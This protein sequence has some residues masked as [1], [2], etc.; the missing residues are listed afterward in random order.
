MPFEHGR[1]E[2]IVYVTENIR[3]AEELAIGLGYG[4]VAQ[5][6]RQPFPR[7]KVPT[8]EFIIGPIHD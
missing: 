2:Q 4:I 8:H 7:I 1:E 5:R 3:D 6:K